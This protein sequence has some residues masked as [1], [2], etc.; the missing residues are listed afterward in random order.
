[1]SKSGGILPSSSVKVSEMEKE[2][3]VSE[4]L[5]QRKGL[6]G[7]K[8]YTLV[9]WVMESECIGA[10]AKKHPE[11]T[12]INVSGSGLGFPGIPNH[13]LEEMASS[14]CKKS[15]DLSG[16]VHAHITSAKITHL[17]QEKIQEEMERKEKSLQNL[18]DLSSQIVTLLKT[19]LETNS[20]YPYGKMTL[21][22]LDFEEEEAFECFL[23][24]VGP[25]LN[26]LLERSF[27]KNEPLSL[28]R[29]IAKWEH[30]KEVV[31]KY[32]LHLRGLFV[33]TLINRRVS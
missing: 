17:T 2:T 14:S 30:F 21:F 18:V 11:V 7:K 9:K 5:L 29:Q 3:R 10:Y 32:H 4:Q 12:F 15:Y 8:V 25:A 33:N 27:P 31:E 6:E 13:S 16:L 24:H 1:M 28:E 19:C 26:R 20:P 22:E 23:P